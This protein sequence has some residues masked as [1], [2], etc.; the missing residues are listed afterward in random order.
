MSVRLIEPSNPDKRSQLVAAIVE[1][2]AQIA[3]S[4]LR[5]GDAGVL[6]NAAL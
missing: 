2:L 4:Q 3:V 1:D 5:Q 6:S